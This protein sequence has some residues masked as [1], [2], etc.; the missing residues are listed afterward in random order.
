[1]R[2]ARPS[3][4]RSGD[5]PRRAVP[6]NEGTAPPRSAVIP[7]PWES[8]MQDVRRAPNAEVMARFR[9]GSI[10]QHTANLLTSSI[11]KT[12]TWKE[13][14]AC[15]KELERAGIEPNVF[16]TTSW[17]SLC[18]KAGEPQR[19]LD[20]YD[21]MRSIGVKPSLRTFNSLISAL[22]PGREAYQSRNANDRGDLAIARMR[23]A[24][25][26]FDTMR[27]EQV[28]PDKVTYSAMISAC[29]RAGDA[30]RAFALFEQMP[31]RIRPDAYIYNGLILACEKVGDAEKAFRV[32]ADMR[33]HGIPP[34]HFT[35]PVLLTLCGQTGDG[36][37]ALALLREMR[38]EGVARTE[39]AYNGAIAACRKGK[40]ASEVPRLLEAAVDDGVFRAELGC[41]GN[42][43]DFHINKVLGE[44]RPGGVSTEVAASL[45]EYHLHRGNVDSCSE[46]IVGWHVNESSTTAK[47][48]KSVIRECMLREGWTP[49]EAPKRNGGRNPGKLIHD[50]D[51]P[52][53]DRAR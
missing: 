42:S 46:Y 41:S 43:L 3:D 31:R 13:G 38:T 20:A 17:I 27:L 26:V 16:V 49:V 8:G 19:A 4:Q 47:T 15:L 36:R 2:G 53:H 1:M 33:R 50:P 32:A 11:M 23:D 40:M 5:L 51:V 52:L 24:F 34:D 30:D 35:Y 29:A 10:D 12:G 22:A 18:Q 9:S 48:I 25:K 37:R 7:G 28:L 45:F 39:N 14:G 6:T 21:Y 44:D